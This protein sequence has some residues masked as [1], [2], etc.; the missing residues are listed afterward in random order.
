MQGNVGRFASNHDTILWYSRSDV[1]LFTPQ[2]EQREV[3]KRQQ[4]RVWD[5]NTKSLKQAKDSEGK[6]IYY[7]ETE[8]TIDDVWRIPYL[9]PADKTENV[10]FQTQKPLELVGRLI[11][12]LAQLGLDGLPALDELVEL[13]GGY[14]RHFPDAR[15]RA[16]RGQARLTSSAGR[17]YCNA[18]A[19]L[20][21]ICWLCATADRPLRST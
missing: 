1:R 7:D 3:V 13:F 5:P 12:A 20:S 14:G 8:R 18:N 10:G 19:C 2:R 9:M 21:A 11:D 16:E 15:E 17:G 6:L 4:K